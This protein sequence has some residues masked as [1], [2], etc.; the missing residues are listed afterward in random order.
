MSISHSIRNILN[1]K[2]QRITFNENVTSHQLIGGVQSLVFNATLAPHS[3]SFCPKCGCVNE[4]FDIIKHG[5]KTIHIKLPR[6]SNQRTFLF[7]KKQRYFCKHCSH[8]FTVSTDCVEDNHSIST[9]T[10]HSCILACK[11]KI[12]IKDIA[13]NH[14]ISHDRVNTW[15]GKLSNRFRVNKRS[16]PK[17]LCFD[18][19]KSVKSVSAAMSF[20][21]SDAQ[22]HQVLD[23]LQDRRLSYLK[24]Y[25]WSYSEDARNH[26]ETVCIDMY[27][28]YIECIQ[29]CFPRAQII[30]DRFHVIQHISKGLSSTRIQMMK[31]HPK[32]YN[33][34]KRYWKLILRNERHL[35]YQNHHSFICFPYLMTQS[36]VVDE[37]LRCDTELEESY[38][39]Y[40][41]L[42]NAYK[43]QREA[44]FFNIV[45]EKHDGVS[46]SMKK[47]L[48]T[49]IRHERSIRNSMRYSFTNGP[50][51]GTNNL[52]KV[53]KRIA[54]GYRDFYNFRSRILLISNTMVRLE[55]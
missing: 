36:Q 11:D 20:I 44:D 28:P 48:K 35:D 42:I 8:T 52:I 17:H 18:E 22:T 49:L 24:N 30:T 31:K 7:L 4:S 54:F 19:F 2:D 5:F 9:N 39:L 33:K 10:Y 46:E 15:V 14:D 34:L 25:F 53:I 23:I 50:L 13:K 32:Y 38:Y 55:Q 12:S 6:V 37:I 21:F 45:Y 3:P 51:E 29:A 40:Q 26:V 43:D 1:I 27:T 47:V 41:K 16:L